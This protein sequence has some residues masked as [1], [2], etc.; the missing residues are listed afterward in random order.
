MSALPSPSA[1]CFH[2]AVHRFALRAYFEDTDLSGMVYHAN[3][4]R[5]FERARSDMVRLLGIDQRAVHEAGEGAYAVSDLAIR[6][7][8]PARLDDTVMIESRVLAIKA[9]SC[10]LLQKAFRDGALLAEAT[11]RVGFV[12]PDGRAK[13]QPAAWRAA[14]ASTIQITET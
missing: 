12:G 6:Y 2:G 1:G 10:R 8:S 7:V 9:A 4:L 3:Y 5:W 14:F 13:R 11:V